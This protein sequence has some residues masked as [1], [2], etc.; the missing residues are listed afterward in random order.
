MGLLGSVGSEMGATSQL[1]LP[2]MPKKPQAP[3]VP[4]APQMPG[5]SGSASGGASEPD[6]DS[7]IEPTGAV[8]VA[9]WINIGSILLVIFTV[10]IAISQEVGYGMPPSELGVFQRFA[11]F[12]V[13]AAPIL[14]LLRGMRPQH[15]GIALIVS[16]AGLFFSGKEVIEHAT[17]QLTVDPNE[18]VL[19][20][21]MFEW[22]FATFIL[23]I[24][25][26]GIMLIWTSSWMAIDYGLVHHYGPSRTWAFASII[27]LGCYILFTLVQ[28]PVQCGWWCPADPTSSGGKGWQFTFAITNASGT[29]ATI[30]ISA[31]VAIMLGIGMLS[32]IAGSVMNHRM[33]SQ[34]DG[35]L[36]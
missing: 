20:R 24:L 19:G 25:G 3:K 12:G 15:Y 34:L 14:N 29:D 10:T 31:F 32:L 17:G 11:L 7:S 26:V 6:P 22:A 28:V 27:W 4:K 2:K 1:Q 16:L 21:P 5:G 9:R 8:G 30:S 18:V 13:C 33:I 35:K 23:V 36:S